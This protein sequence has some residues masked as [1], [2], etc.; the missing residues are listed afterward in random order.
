MKAIFTLLGC[1]FIAFLSTAQTFT[2]TELPTGLSTPWEMTY[3]PDNFLWLTEAGG[4]V[5]RVNSTTGE[6]VVVYTAPDYFGGSRLEQSPLCFEPNIGTGTLGLALHP[7]FSTSATAYIYYVYSYNS[8]T[9]QAPKTQFKIVRLTWDASSQRV[10]ANLDLVRNLPTG[11]DHLGGRLLA[12]KQ[13]G[14]PYLYFTTGDNGI[15]DANSPDCYVPQ[16]NNPNN[17]AQDPA[18]KNGKVHRFNIDGTVPSDNPIPGNSFFTRGHRN[19]QGLMYNPV[20]NVVYDIEH[21]DRTDD[22]INVLVKGMNYGWKN[23]RGYHGDDNYP[24]EAA[25]IQSY[26]PHPLIANDQLKPAFYAWCAVPQPTNPN[27]ADWCS[28]APSD[29]LYYN[30]NAIAAWTNSLLVVTLKAGTNTQPQLYQFKLNPDGITLVASTPGEPNPRTFFSADQALN[31][32]LRDIAVSPDG[33]KIYLINNNFGGTD[34]DKIIVYTYAP[35]TT[36]NQAPVATAGSNQTLTLPTSS[37]RLSGAGTDA[38]GTIAS[39][40]WSQLSGPAPATFSSST[41]PAPTLS[42]L[43]AGT[44]VFSLVVTDNEGLRSAPSQTTL[45]INPGSALYRIHAGGAPLSTSLGAFA[46]DQYAA[47][48]TTYAT[49]QPIA[50]TAD[51]ALYQTERYGSAFAYAFPVS[52]GQQYQVVLHF[53]EVYATQVGQRVFDVAAEG[54]QVLDNYDIVKKAG[55]LTATTERFTLTVNDDELNL[56]FRSLAS[57]GGVDNAKVSA[58]EVYALGTPGPTAVLRLNAGSGPLA[59][60]LGPF[61]ADQYA[62]GGAVFSTDQPIAGTEDDALYQTERYG[63]FTYNLPVANGQY[64]VKLHFAEL[65]WNSAGQRVFDVA[66]EGSP[67][68][69]AYDIVR[70][71]GPLTATTESFPVTVTDGQLTLAFAPGPGGVDQPKVAAIEVLEAAPTP[72]LR[73]KAGGDALTTSFGRF[74]AD[75]FFAGGSDFATN[76][77]IAGTEDDALYQTER[78]GS[79]LYSLPVPNGQYTIKL[80]FAELYWNTVGQRVFD[81]AA[82]GRTV[83]KAYDIVQKAGPL[84]ATTESFPVTVSDGV[85]S[86]A[87]APGAAGVDQPKVSA[88]E[89]LRAS[90]ALQAVAANSAARPGASPLA[91]HAP[92]K[93]PDYSAQVQLYPNPTAEGRVSVTLPAAFQGEVGYTLVSSLGT[94]L[95]QGQR[96]FSGPGHPLSFDFSP[97]LLAPGLYYLQ[98]SAPKARALVKLLRQ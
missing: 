62:S 16:A 92:A 23:V 38:D 57:E 21:G 68:L 14:I 34:K 43:V 42:G 52:R 89:V 73:L 50:G 74:A 45:T 32:R 72:V 20:Q 81:V 76:Q 91:T 94:T 46:A 12:I 82:E 1:L 54:T 2:R 85:L 28:V 18:A 26:V 39:Y 70:K 84:T 29:G 96:R 67:V 27:S 58:I 11:Y 9:E 24:G 15:S 55:P 98:L 5:S 79:F 25:Y 65:Y 36:P 13:N 71:V 59:T 69:Q 64:T 61:A 49:D 66:A 83:L 87:F 17:L 97:Q 35:Q 31:G 44:Y 22:E 47:G 8:G 56:T 93:R 77:P 86:L 37:T 19:P 48:G 63:R 41:D 53:A 3:G 60:R 4:R 30:S 10:V 7:D 33:R 6:K 40:A 78:Y 51:Q 90:S 75:Q 95:S 80:H 88:I